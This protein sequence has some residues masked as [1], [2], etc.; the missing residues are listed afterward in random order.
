MSFASRRMVASP[1]CEEF[2]DWKLLRER[3][4]LKLRAGTPTATLTSQPKRSPHTA[5]PRP[6]TQ[7]KTGNVARCV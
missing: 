5:L 2:A 7:P 4:Y 1:F 3:R 6:P